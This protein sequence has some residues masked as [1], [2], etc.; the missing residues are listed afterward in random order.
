MR[1]SSRRRMT[2]LTARAAAA[3]AA[4][5]SITACSGQHSP[6]PPKAVSTVDRQ[7]RVC[8]FTG[9]SA[10]APTADRAWA[11]ISEAAARPH[12]L[13]VQRY[14]L[15]SGVNPGSYLGTLAQMRCTVIVTV[16][17]D[18]RPPTGSAA[19]GP[20]YIVISASSA[21]APHVTHLSPTATAATVTT[22]V[23]KAVRDSAAT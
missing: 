23:T 8:L 19:D 22:A 2:V 4:L 18:L 7:P 12:A 6:R 15:P 9:D 13:T 16:G 20:R 5:V 11:G 14:R 21:P 3:A 1:Q 17:D 10:D